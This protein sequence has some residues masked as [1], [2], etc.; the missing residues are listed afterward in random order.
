VV[1]IVAPADWQV[2]KAVRLR[3]LATDPHAFL[4][5]AE[6]EE[7]LSEAKWRERTKRTAVAVVHEQPVGIVAWRGHKHFLELVG[8]W[9][10]PAQ[11]GRGVAD[12]LCRHV[13]QHSTE[14]QPLRLAVRAA[15]TP[16]LRF[17]ERFGFVHDS[18]TT[19]DQSGAL[20]WLRLPG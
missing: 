14:R 1:R 6:Q 10:D 5:S 8:L 7:L 16:A 3:A 12:A 4:S 18:A 13:V 9:V 11:R 19:A 15:N 20:V 17:Y 2:V